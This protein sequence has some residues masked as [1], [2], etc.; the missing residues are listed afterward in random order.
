MKRSKISP[1][2]PIYQNYKNVVKGNKTLYV[3]IS[4]LYNRNT[5]EQTSEDFNTDKPSDLSQSKDEGI[6]NTLSFL[7]FSI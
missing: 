5:T 4:L 3:R 2:N 1:N 6:T 7:F